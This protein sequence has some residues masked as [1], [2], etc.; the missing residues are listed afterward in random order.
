MA[1][2]EDDG[3]LTLFV[4]GN[5]SIDEIQVRT[6]ARQERKE[7]EVDVIIYLILGNVGWRKHD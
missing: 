3:V 2:I 1:S 6:Y 5:Q 4:G 7:Y